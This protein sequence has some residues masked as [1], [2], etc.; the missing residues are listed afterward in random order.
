MYGMP[1]AFTLLSSQFIVGP[2][3]IGGPPMSTDPTLEV[4]ARRSSVSLHLG[5]SLRV[6]SPG[7]TFNPING[8]LGDALASPLL[9]GTEQGGPR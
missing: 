7:A 1:I 5:T 4:V 6:N 9:S 3:A 8:E 2:H